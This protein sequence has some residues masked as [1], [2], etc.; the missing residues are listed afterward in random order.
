[1]TV[2]WLAIFGAGFLLLTF[3]DNL[4]WVAKRLEAEAIGTPVEQGRETRI[5][6]AIDGHFWVDATVNGQHA[7][8]LVDSGA[9]VTTISREL[10]QAAGVPDSGQRIVVDT[11]NGPAPATEAYANKLQVQSISRSDFPIDIND[12]DET[13]VL[14]MNF[15]SS[16]SGWKVEGNYLVLSQR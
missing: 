14:G 6:M 1:M 10:A 2:A 4:D 9:S 7:R 16:L 3:R 5:P 12:R 15:L 11:A 8:F 13:N